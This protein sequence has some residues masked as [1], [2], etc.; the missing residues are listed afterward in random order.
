MLFPSNRKEQSRFLKSTEG[1]SERMQAKRQ[2]LSQEEF[3]ERSR[4]KRP[5]KS[6]K[7]YIKIAIE[8]V[9]GCV[10]QPLPCLW[11]HVHPKITQCPEAC[12]PALHVD[13]AV[14]R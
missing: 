2:Y 9:K 3:I 6:D 11:H 1:A 8:V 13:D 10:A 4:I 14:D 12:P 7:S 5:K